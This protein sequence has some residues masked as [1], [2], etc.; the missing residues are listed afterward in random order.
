MIEDEIFEIIKKNTVNIVVGVKPEIITIEKK[1]KDVGADS[2][3]RADILAKTI[4]DLGIKI[5][6]VEL[7]K[8]KVIKDIVD[9]LH[10]HQQR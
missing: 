8:A 6:L 3:D 7:G 2:I 4:E 1:L 10:R 5:P 9:I